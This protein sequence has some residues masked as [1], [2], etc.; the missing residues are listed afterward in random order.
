MPRPG[1]PCTQGKWTFLCICYL[2]CTTTF[3]SLL[4][5]Y[6]FDELSLNSSSFVLHLCSTATCYI[7]YLYPHSFGIFGGVLSYILRKKIRFSV[8]P[9]HICSFM[10]LIPLTALKDKF[11]SKTSQKCVFIWPIGCQNCPSCVN[12]DI[13]PFSFHHFW[14]NTRT[15]YHVRVPSERVF[16]WCQT[17]QL[18]IRKCVFVIH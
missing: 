18:G 16:G 3:M 5:L 8:S 17:F 4:L 13:L 9:L 7:S 14:A 1:S 11:M 2:M 15:I 12:F 10:T 6:I